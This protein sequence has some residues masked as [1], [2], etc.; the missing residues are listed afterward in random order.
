V[1]TDDRSWEFEDA[2]ASAR[3]RRAAFRLPIALDVVV[4]TSSG[5]AGTERWDSTRGGVEL[6]TVTEDLSAGGLK[7]RAPA[8]LPTAKPLELLLDIEAK[9]LPLTGNVAYARP[10]DMG[11][12][13]GVQF[14][15][16]ERNPAQGQLTRFLFARERRR[17]PQVSLMYPV[18]CRETESGQCQGTTEVCSPGFAWLILEGKVAIGARAKLSVEV[19]GTEIGLTGRA[20]ACARTGNAWRVGMEFDDIVPTWRDLIIERREGRR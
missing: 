15:N 9:P 2:R 10:D 1:R 12:G 7:F 20:V 14:T 6:R 8:R 3:N 11:V 19:G 17:L 4:R 18:V 16:V 13:V 5:T